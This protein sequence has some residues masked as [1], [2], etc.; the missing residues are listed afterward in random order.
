MSGQALGVTVSESIIAFMLL[1]CAEFLSPW[2]HSFKNKSMGA[3][4][5][6]DC[7]LEF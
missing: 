1:L 5:G 2:E 4:G 3:F 7:N 6:G